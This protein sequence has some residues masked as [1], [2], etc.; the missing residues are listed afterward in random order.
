[1]EREIVTKG[2]VLETKRS[3]AANRFL[4][5]LTVDNGIVGVLSYG[6]QKGLKATKAEIGTDGTY[7]LYYNPVKKTYSLEDLD[8]IKDHTRLRED[9]NLNYC[10]LFF[11]EL[12]LRTEGGDS[13]S[14]YALLHDAFNLLES[15]AHDP[16]LVLIQFV[17]SLARILGVRDSLQE[18]PLCGKTYEEKEILGFSFDLTAPCCMNCATVQ[19]EMVLTSGMRRYLAY[20]GSM[21]FVQAVAVPLNPGQK[22]RLKRWMLRYAS[23]VAQGHLRTLD[24]PILQNM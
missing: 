13:A 24:D 21:D 5:I 11:C 4:R 9:L 7:Y 6:A 14:C 18:C 23:L 20:T 10:S 19:D 16:S 1:M 2:I 12:M 3:G 22:Q 17:W 8:L 15:S